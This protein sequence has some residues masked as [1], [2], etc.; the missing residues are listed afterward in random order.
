MV[1]NSTSSEHSYFDY[2]DKEKI[3]EKDGV[4]I[5]AYNT[6]ERKNKT[7][8]ALD[9]IAQQIVHK[10]ENKVNSNLIKNLN[11]ENMNKEESKDEVKEEKD[12]I[13]HLENELEKSPVI[14]EKNIFNK[15]KEIELSILTKAKE[16]EKVRPQSAIIF[17]TIIKKGNKNEDFSIIASTIISKKENVVNQNMTQLPM[18]G[19]YIIILEQTFDIVAKKNRRNREFNKFNFTKS[20]SLN[21]SYISDI[22]SSE[23]R[24]LKQNLINQYKE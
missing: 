1:S 7:K 21:H 22:N 15:N 14:E 2:N 24:K 20:L 19:K 18:K 9:N 11:W 13:I 6:K 5:L 4:V 12:N 16:N 8:P 10:K 17:P 23:I 3:T